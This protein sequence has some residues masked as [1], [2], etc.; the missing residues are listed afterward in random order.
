VRFT[1]AHIIP[2]DLTL[3]HSQLEKEINEKLGE[4]YHQLL[5]ASVDRQ[6]SEK[7]AKLKETLTNLS[8]IFPGIF[9]SNL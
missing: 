5:Q 8:R 7:E 3:S 4:I 2:T 9:F 6:E 1:L